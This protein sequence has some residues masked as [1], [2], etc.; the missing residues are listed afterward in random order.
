MDVIS[1]MNKIVNVL[2]FFFHFVQSHMWKHATCDSYDFSLTNDVLSAAIDFDR[3]PTRQTAADRLKTYVDRIRTENLQC[4]VIFGCSAGHGGRHGGGGG[5]SVRKSLRTVELGCSFRT[6]DRELL[7]EHVL[8]HDRN[9][10]LSSSRA[11]DDSYHD[12]SPHPLPPT[13]P[14][15]LVSPVWVLPRG[16]AVPNSTSTVSVSGLPALTGVISEGN[17]SSVEVVNSRE[18]PAT[19]HRAYIV[20][21]DLHFR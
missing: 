10:A 13:L 3:K 8:S 19:V 12:P 9:D 7:H 1:G 5:A 16:E 20:E 21:N 15:S 2:I 11:F 14:P 17:A 4:H 6:L 18:A